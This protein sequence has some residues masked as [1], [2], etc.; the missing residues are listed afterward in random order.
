MNKEELIQRLDDI[1]WEDFEVKEAKTDVPKSVRDTVSSFSNTSGG[2]IVFGVSQK[3]KR[4]FVSGVNNPEKIE[5]DFTTSLRGDIYNSKIIPESKKYKFDEGTVLAFKIPPSN[6][7]PVYFNNPKN[8]FIRTASGDQRASQEEIDAMYRDQAYGTLTSRIIEDSD[9][10]DLNQNSIDRYRDYLSR[11]N[12][13]HR[14][15][16]F[17]KR[18][19]LEKTQ[20][21]IKDKISYAGLLFFGKEDS[22]QRYFPDFRIDLLEIPGTS[23]ADAK[24]RYTFRLEE[25]ENL[26]EYYFALFDRLRQRL[27]L[28]FQLSSEGFAIE[29]YPQLE[30]IRE[31]LVN[32]LMHTDYFSAGKPRIRIFDN[33][34]EFWNSGSPPKS[35]EDLIKAD[36][37]LPRNPIIAKLFRVVKL[38]E[39]AGYGFD[40]MIGGWRQYT[41]N[42]PEFLK[43]IDSTTAI[44]EFPPKLIGAITD[45]LNTDLIRSKLEE[46]KDLKINSTEVQVVVEMLKDKNI[47]IQQLSEV[48][49]VSTTAIENNIGK[50][51]AKGLIDRIGADK[52]GFWKVLVSIE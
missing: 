18:E 37:T 30:A 38:A 29:N 2:W 14:Y 19:L 28:P 42:A 8:T 12:P 50:L 7:K 33:R 39:N 34:V 36:I 26:W 1:E 27:N 44:F 43:D 20:V 31:A 5:Q 41:K 35:I 9:I 11:F 13:S 17:T 22:I 49:G 24:T 15:T 16:K 48:V 10:S 32:L 21:I 52:G 45:G 46:R 51:K 25:Q 40:K 6:K 3:G 47:T 23:Y 4:F